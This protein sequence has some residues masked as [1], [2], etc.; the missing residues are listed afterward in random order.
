MTTPATTDAEEDFYFLI[1]IDGQQE[2]SCDTL[3][4]AMDEVEAMGDVTGAIVLVGG[5]API[6]IV[7]YVKG[8][9]RDATE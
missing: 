2:L 3:Q 9:V 6:P 7:K 8:Q 1:Q 4:E 5:P